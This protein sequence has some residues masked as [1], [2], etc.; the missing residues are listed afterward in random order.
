V[1]ADTVLPDERGGGRAAV[2]HLIAQ[3]HR[4]IGVLAVRQRAARQQLLAGYAE[5]MKAAGLTVDPAWTTLDA[6]GLD[7]D[8]NRASVTAVLCADRPSTEA[9]LR[10]LAGSRRLAVVGFGDFEI[11]DLVSPGITVLSYDPTLIGRTAGEL[12][13]RRL[14]G[15][16]VPPRQ[17][18]VPVRLI[19]RGSAEFPPPR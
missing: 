8:L 6:D 16:E 1:L 13:V 4:R 19:A 18:E 12:L 15:D 3:G 11:A 9:A 5:A 17:V 7:A 2:A 10:A 14:A